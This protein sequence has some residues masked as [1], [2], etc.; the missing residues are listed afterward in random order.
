MKSDNEQLPLLLAVDIGN[1][2]LK[3]LSGNE[4]SAYDLLENNLIDSDY[5]KLQKNLNAM[6]EETVY[7]SVSSVNKQANSQIFKILENQPNFKLVDLTLLLEKQKLLDFAH[8]K[9]IGSDR[10]L[11]L[12]G[13]LSEFEP[14]LI[15]VDCG[16]AITVNLALENDNA[17][18]FK[19]YMQGGAIFAGFSLQNHVL[20]NKTSGIGAHKPGTPTT[21]AGS[22][23]NTA[24]ASGIFYSITGGIK[25]IIEQM[26]ID[27]KLDANTRIILTGGSAVLVKDFLYSRLANIIYEPKLILRGILALL[28]RFI[29]H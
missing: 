3:I 11:G 18:P 14:P 1:S 10:L 9:Y 26:I 25:Q 20:T 8:I 23:T 7:Y 27:F 24:L 5:V 15:T 16:T 28:E 13:G 2:R 22:S 19:A 17:S 4:Y 12:V 6:N 29:R 21:S